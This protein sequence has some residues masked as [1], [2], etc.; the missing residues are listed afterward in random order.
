MCLSLASLVQPSP[1][2]SSLVEPSPSPEPTRV[3]HFAGAPLQG[4]L[5][6]LPTNIRQGGKA[7]QRQTLQLITKINT[8]RPKEALYY[9][10]LGSINKDP[11]MA[12]WSQMTPLVLLDH[13]KAKNFDKLRVYEVGDE[14]IKVLQHQHRISDSNVLILVRMLNLVHETLE[15]L[16]TGRKMF[17]ILEI[18]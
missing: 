6:A 13:L 8:L 3:K 15:H 10:P 16:F 11:T 5:L 12:R 9:R 18:C 14:Q 1:S 2:Q 4:R 7:Y 17:Q